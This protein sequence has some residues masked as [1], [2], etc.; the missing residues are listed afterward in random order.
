VREKRKH[1]ELLAWQQAIKLVEA[2]YLATR[3]F[4][5]EEIYGLTA[6]IRRE[7]ISIPSN[8]AEGAARS[9]RK[10]FLH[11]LSMARGSLSEIETQLIIAQDLGYLKSDAEIFQFLDKVFAL[12]GGLMKSLRT[13]D[14]Q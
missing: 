4:P 8:I 13:I 1:H 12:V 9:A 5:K 10:E 6:Q 14:N 11:F 3:P 7:A 2:V